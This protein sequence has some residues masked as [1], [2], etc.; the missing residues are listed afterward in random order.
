MSFAYF[1]ELASYS[2]KLTT[3]LQEIQT[4]ARLILPGEPAKHAI[5]ERTEWIDRV[6][7]RRCQ[8]NLP[9]TLGG[10]FLMYSIAV[11]IIDYRILLH[12]L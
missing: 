7:V 3:S 6:L 11:C 5:S 8:V 1:A 4:A 9:P 12:L 2:Q 10:L